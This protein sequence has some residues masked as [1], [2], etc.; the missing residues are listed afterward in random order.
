MV[1]ARASFFAPSKIAE[2][3]KFNAISARPA[4]GADLRGHKYLARGTCFASS[5]SI[6]VIYLHFFR[7]SL[8]GKNWFL[9]FWWFFFREDLFWQR[10]A[11]PGLGD[12]KNVIELK[13]LITVH[14]VR[15]GWGLSPVS[16]WWKKEGPNDW[17]SVRRE[18][19]GGRREQLSAI[20]TIS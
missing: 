12:R 1:T 4:R 5:S 19:W 18:E 7:R 9:N 15:L 3:P 17:W 8:D 11:G 13:N 16:V 2:S 10:R 20:R 6:L 14:E